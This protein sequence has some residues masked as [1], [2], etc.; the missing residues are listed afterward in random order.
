M[1]VSTRTSIFDNNIP[2]SHWQWREAVRGKRS[3]EALCTLMSSTT[4]TLSLVPLL[5]MFLSE[6]IMDDAEPCLL[7]PF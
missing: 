1:Y 5:L 4:F 6:D 7:Y 2:V 3:R